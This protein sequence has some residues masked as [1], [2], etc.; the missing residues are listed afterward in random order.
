M[1][2]K[3]YE[4]QPTMAGPLARSLARSLA[5]FFRL[6]SPHLRALL[7]NHTHLAPSFIHWLKFTVLHPHALLPLHPFSILR[8]GVHQRQIGHGGIPDRRRR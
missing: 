7:A 1:E 2:I 8:A 6:Y 3:V 5:Q 4:I